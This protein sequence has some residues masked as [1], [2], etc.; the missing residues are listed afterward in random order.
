MS[1]LPL[2]PRAWIGEAPFPWPAAHT[3]PGGASVRACYFVRDVEIAR[4]RQD[5]PFL[6][7]SLTDRHGVVPA[8]AWDNAL[9]IADT[10]RA[11]SYIGIEAVSEI[12]NGELQLCVETAVPLQV[13]LED[14]PL[15]LPSSPRGAELMGAELDALIASIGDSGLRSLAQALLGAESRTGPGF[16]LAPAAKQNH[17]AYLGGLLEHTLSVARACDL[18]A[19]H[20]G[21]AL[22]RDLLVTAALLHDVGKVREI[23]A[24]AGFPYT[25][26]G[27]LLG[28]I[29]L[30]LQMVDQ[31]AATLEGLAPSRLLLLRHLIAAHQ[32]RYEWQSP[33]EPATLEALVLHYVDDLDAKYTQA[34]L[35]V[36]RAPLGW[37][38]Y[39]RSF[40]REFLRH[41][42]LA[43]P[44]APGAPPAPA[45]A[46]EP[47]AAPGEVRRS[48]EAR[49][50]RP[51]REAAVPPPVPEP[52]GP[53][54]SGDPTP[55]PS[56]AGAL[57]MSD[58]TLDLF[59]PD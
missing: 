4:T 36:G 46:A 31:A 29:L 27:K 23:G 3:L 11:G 17:H 54:G 25:D 58:D 40:R 56:S 19:G 38:A 35:L 47:A 37:T 10:A 52:P 42:D 26:E 16:R 30:G 8:R 51:P 44:A 21:A 49:R 20:Y 9:D 15:F 43:G 18:L 12:Y 41:H 45:P 6:R 1:D 48:Q 50:R 39:D 59:E 34:A 14:L 7:L 57:R 55:P 5:Q 22:D 53:A 13:E 33:R 24:R 2:A 32:G 28:H